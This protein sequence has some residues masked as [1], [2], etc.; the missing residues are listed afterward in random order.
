MTR[1]KLD[2]IERVE[3]QRDNCSG[4]ERY[5]RKMSGHSMRFRFM[6][7][8]GLL[9]LL[10]CASSAQTKLEAN[11]AILGAVHDGS[12]KGVA[13]ASVRLQSR[14][15]SRVEERKTDPTG[16]FGFSELKTGIYVLS[17]SKD[18]Q[19]SNE[20]TVSITTAGAVQ[21]IELTLSNSAQSSSNG[22]GQQKEMEF[23]DAPNFTVSA[24]TDWTAAGGHGS[25][26]SLR[27]SEALT[28]QTLALRPDSNDTSWVQSHSTASEQALRAVLEKSPG[29]LNA[30]EELGRFYLETERYSDAVAPLQKAYEID[31]S[32][33]NEYKLAFAL[34]RSG[35]LASA[36][37]HLLR[38]SSQANKAEWHGLAG[39]IAEKS[40]DPL[41]A[42][43]EFEK[44]AKADPNEGNYFAWGSELL[45]HRAIWQAVDVFESGAR[46][47]PKSSRILTALGAALFAGAMYEEAARRLCAASDLRP[48]DPAPYLF[49]GRVEVAA[50]NS[51]PCIESRLERFVRMQP[52]NP[53][54]NFYYGMS[55]WKERGKR[56]DGQTF[57]QVETYLNRALAADPKCSS[58][59]LQLGILRASRA[60]FKAA[61]EFYQKAI[62]A[63]PQSTEAHYRLG[64]AYDRLGERAKAAEEFKLHDQ[65]ER[66]QASVVDRQRKEVK[67]FL[68]QVGRSAQD[69][70]AQP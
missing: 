65:L 2:V 25:D 16:N 15:Q 17:A 38:L 67:Q 41:N 49:M 39:E 21:R 7:F 33:E 63:D 14:G 70:S 46:A 68:V 10:G 58:A 36:R 53:L 13:E 54:A 35:S 43:H 3:D 60:D 32:L 61:S 56:V 23:S 19:H 69:R 57:G 42:V 45:E 22:T 55:Y 24:V 51:L 44:A 6:A 31:G 52:T 64:T 47:F 50:P 37:E 12:G 5:G 66:E 11:S 18:E 62:A 4:K 28:R 27:A 1:E 48:E 26:T 20:V 59:Y 29:D 8:L 40:G 9:A 30:N 34:T